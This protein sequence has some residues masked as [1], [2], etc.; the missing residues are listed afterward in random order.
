MREPDT[1]ALVLERANVAILPSPIPFPVFEGN[2]ICLNQVN[3]NERAS[4][5]TVG[6]GLL[7]LCILIKICIVICVCLFVYQLLCLCFCKEHNL[8]T[9][10]SHVFGLDINPRS[11]RGYYGFGIVARPPRPRPRPQRFLVNAIEATVLIRSTSNF[12]IRC[13][14]GYSRRLL[15]LVLKF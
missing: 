10:I 9:Q 6:C 14:W 15:F 3:R 2:K 11:I 8:R 7:S 4:L 13:I 5:T 1:T 12:S